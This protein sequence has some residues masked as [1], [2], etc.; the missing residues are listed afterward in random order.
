MSIDLNSDP[1]L[2]YLAKKMAYEHELQLA[3]K[4]ARENDA[5]WRSF[6]KPQE[7]PVPFTINESA[8]LTWDYLRK[9][10]IYDVPRPSNIKFQDTEKLLT[11]PCL[12]Q[13]KN[14]KLPLFL[15]VTKSRSE[16]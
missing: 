5:K 7:K 10:D 8:T 16:F 9:C 14:Q 4:D 12:S 1:E 13:C 2:D 6:M 15:A 11:D 3:C